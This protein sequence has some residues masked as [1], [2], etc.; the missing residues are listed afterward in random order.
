MLFYCRYHRNIYEYTW[1]NRISKYWEMIHK[2]YTEFGFYW[3]DQQ[4]WP[5]LRALYAHYR[6]ALTH[7]HKQRW[8]CRQRH[9]IFSQCLYHSICNTAVH[10]LDD[11]RANNLPIYAHQFLNQWS[12]KRVYYI[13]YV[14][15]IYIILNVVSTQ[16]Q[17]CNILFISCCCEYGAR[18][19]GFMHTPNGYN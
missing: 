6:A 7:T 12:E 4:E 1:T 14:Y 9:Y 16:M 15:T 8:A 5:H 17:Y 11:E 19:H 13:I 10:W 18:T 3:W 2:H